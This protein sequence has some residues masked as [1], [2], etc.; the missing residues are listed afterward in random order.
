MQRRKGDFS[1]KMEHDTYL[2]FE[3]LKEFMEEMLDN[4]QIILKNQKKIMDKLGIEYD[5]PEED[6]NEEDELDDMEIEEEKATISLP[7][8]GVEDDDRAESKGD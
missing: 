8:V 6:E 5:E 3:E 1:V 4:E 2:A 7:E